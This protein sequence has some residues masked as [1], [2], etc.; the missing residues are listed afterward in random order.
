MRDITRIGPTTLLVENKEQKM[1]KVIIAKKQRE[2]KEA[3]TL[4]D[5][6]H[7][8]K[9]TCKELIEDNSVKQ[10]EKDAY[11][12][13]LGWIADALQDTPFERT[14]SMQINDE[15]E[16]LFHE[17][18]QLLRRVIGKIDPGD[19]PHFGSLHEQLNA[20]IEAGEMAQQVKTLIKAEEI[21]GTRQFK[22]N[23]AKAKQHLRK[24]KK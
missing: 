9:N 16:K 23:D 3:E 14:T 18:H 20:V 13:C 6:L 8:I 4:R 2:M 22:R 12:D 10:Y 7:V 11:T 15:R 1:N 19:P 21:V 5:K 24:E 17:M